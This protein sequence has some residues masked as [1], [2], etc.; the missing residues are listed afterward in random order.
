MEAFIS[1]VILLVISVI[2]SAILHYGFKYTSGA[3][4][5]HWAFV[6]KIIVG[7]FGAWWGTTVYGQW[8]EGLNYQSVYYIPAILGAF[9]AV[10]FGVAFFM[11]LRGGSR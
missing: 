5:N 2:V 1:F 4:P 8:W 6:T 10:A 7:Y 3:V 11:A 9:S